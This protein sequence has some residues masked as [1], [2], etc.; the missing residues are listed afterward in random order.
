MIDVASSV[1]VEPATILR[2][3]YD[4][5]R[6][7]ASLIGSPSAVTSMPST[8]SQ[9][10]TLAVWRR[11][12]RGARAGQSLLI[13]LKDPGSRQDI[14]AWLLRQGHQVQRLQESDAAL[15]LR[16]VVQNRPS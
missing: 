12:L 7:S 8:S 9:N 15:T 1:G 16:L 4:V 13:L 10:S 5:V 6:F 14:P 11:R 2:S 3:A